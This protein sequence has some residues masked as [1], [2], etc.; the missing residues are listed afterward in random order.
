MRTLA[1]HDAVWLFSLFQD[2]ATCLYAMVTKGSRE[3]LSKPFQS[4]LQLLGASE[5]S[6]ADTILPL[7]LNHRLSAYCILLHTGHM[8]GVEPLELRGLILAFAEIRISMIRTHRLRASSSGCRGRSQTLRQWTQNSSYLII[9]TMKP[10][11]FQ[12]IRSII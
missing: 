10:T 6:H 8:R 5:D 12:I 7:P 3:S 4:K 9:K 2:N 1:T 11:A